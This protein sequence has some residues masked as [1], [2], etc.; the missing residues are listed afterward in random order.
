MLKILLALLVVSLTAA[1][2]LLSDTLGLP[3]WAAAWATVAALLLL[4]SMVA[5][6]LLQR[7]SRRRRDQKRQAERSPF[8]QTLGNLR[9]RCEHA[10]EALRAQNAEALPWVLMLGQ[11]GAGKTAALRS[12]GVHFLDGLGPERFIAG[13]D[14]SPTESVQFLASDRLVL[15]DTAGRYLCETADHE[16]RREWL[17]LLNLL[18]THRAEPLSGVVLT[19]AAPTLA[20]LP[21]E[22]AAAL[23]LSLRR[24]LEDIQR[25]FTATFPVYLLVTRVDQLAGLTRLFAADPGERFGFEVELSGAGASSARRVAEGPLADLGLSLERRA[26]ALLEHSATPEERSELYRAPGHFRR[27]AERAADLLGNLFPDHGQADAPIFR[28]LYFAS[29]GP[30]GANLSAAATTDLELQALARD[31]GNPPQRGAGPPAPLARPVFLRG[32]FA[33]VLPDDRWISGWTRRRQGQRRV[34]HGLRVALLASAALGA[35]TLSLGAAQSNHRL[36]GALSAA[37]TALQ[38]DHPLPGAT[39]VPLRPGQLA[40][41]QAVH[42]TLHAHRDDGAPWSLR[43]GLY[44]GGELADEVER[45][46]FTAAQERLLKPSVAQAQAHLARLVAQH[47][48]ST[49][50]LPTEQFWPA[51]DALH[52]YILLTRPASGAGLTLQD[53]SQRMWLAAYLPRAW[54][55]TLGLGERERAEAI[56][57]S[58]EYI[59]ALAARAGDLLPREDPL[60]AAA[61]EILHRTNRGQLWADELSLEQIPGASA[62][63]LA[64]IASAAWLTTKEG[65]RVEAAYTRKGWDYVRTKI[66]CPAAADDRYLAAALTIDERSCIDERASLQGQ[67]FKRYVESWT[68]FLNDVYV[69]EPEGYKDI[70][71]QIV[72]MTTPGGPGVNALENLFRVVGENA[73]LPMASDPGPAAEPEDFIPSVFL[74]ARRKGLIL[75]AADA[76]ASDQVTVATVRDAFKPYYSYGYSPPGSDAG[77]AASPLQ[78]YILLLSKVA[79]P[80][81][82]YTKERN[83]EALTQAKT[84]ASQV[85]ELVHNEHFTQRDRRWT[86]ALEGI[87]DPPV[88]GLLDAINRGSLDELTMRW[89]NE[90][91]YP[92][93][94]MRPC[95]PFNKGATCDVSGDEVAGLFQPQSGKLWALYNDALAARFPFQGDRYVP[96]PQGYNSRVKLNPAVARF[97]TNAR[98]LGDV[99]FPAGSPGP[100][101]SFAVQFKPLETASQITLTVDGTPISY[102]NSDRDRFQP[103][104]WPGQGGAPLTRLE[105]QIKGGLSKVEGPGFWGLYRLIE[106]GNVMRSGRLVVVK[107]LFNDRVTSAE[108]RLNPQ[109]GAGNPL[110]GKVRALPEPGQTPEVGLM[111]IFRERRLAPPRQL[112]TSG[113]SCK[114]LNLSGSAPPSSSGSAPPAS[115][116][117]P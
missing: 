106:Q 48:D 18:H 73:Q 53:P 34:R 56:T 52:I 16:D 64:T 86:P 37:I 85:Y 59:D 30:S 11:S 1:L 70:E 98:E 83:G 105:A 44:Q 95:Y 67:Y 116:L 3:G 21:P 58:Q 113:T 35:L 39:R 107:L 84:V 65:R 54:S 88:R 33:S 26:F 82:L 80:L 20:S 110:F 77:A 117:A 91:V 7:R 55:D 13:G 114:P 109:D 60:V 17:A 92:F 43:L 2:W 69:R 40:P 87:L 51:V 14:V 25:E 66:R 68:Q 61:R 27:V 8:H 57:V 9:S 99:L 15:V 24:R 32:L 47:K 63:S 112:F 12:S 38:S 100:S 89:C 36:Q 97:L 78:A 102:N 104:T 71:S 76:T 49:A 72:D 115:T 42:R 75:T 29:A 108:I 45:V 90:V 4:V 94:T 93:D 79:H 101:F 81:G 46:Y 22:D 96:A 23:G 62:I 50:I 28:G 103:I 6:E 74:L 10:L 111:D 41:I 19:V 31:Y 5:L